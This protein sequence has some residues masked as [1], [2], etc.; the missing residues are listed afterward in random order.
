LAEQSSRACKGCGCQALSAAPRRSEHCL[1]GVIVRIDVKSKDAEETMAQYGIDDEPRLIYKPR[2]VSSAKYSK[3]QHHKSIKTLI[4]V[5]I[6][7][8]LS[9]AFY[10][11]KGSLLD[12][13]ASPANQTISQ[14]AA[15]NTHVPKKL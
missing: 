11:F 15:D 9:V 8:V 1:P 14:D 12:T 4:G 7:L 13:H 3:R 5:A 10:E 2:I 6:V